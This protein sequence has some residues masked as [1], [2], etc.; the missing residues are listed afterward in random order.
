MFKNLLT[1]L[2]VIDIDNY[3]LKI[4]FVINEKREFLKF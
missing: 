3:Y 1:I 4:E 2:F